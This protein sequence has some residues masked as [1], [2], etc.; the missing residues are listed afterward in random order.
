MKFTSHFYLFFLVTPLC[1]Q[2]DQ[3]SVCN[4]KYSL[5]AHAPLYDSKGDIIL[6]LYTGQTVDCLRGPQDGFIRVRVSQHGQTHEGVIFEGFLKLQETK[7]NIILERKETIGS[8]NRFGSAYSLSGNLSYEDDPEIDQFFDQRITKSLHPPTQGM[9][10]VNPITGQP[11][12]QLATSAN[13]DSGPEFLKAFDKYALS[14]NPLRSLYEASP[15]TFKPAEVNYERFDNSPAK[16]KLGY[17]P[18]KVGTDGYKDQLKRYQQYEMEYI[19]KNYTLPFFI[20][21]ALLFLLIYRKSFLKRLN[22]LVNNNFSNE[23]NVRS[24]YFKVPRQKVGSS[25][26][27]LKEE[28]ETLKILKNEGIIDEDEFIERK[29]RLRQKY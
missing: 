18:H 26:D 27:E 5:T 7:E 16:E 20:V 23:R 25:I 2:N 29:E 1:A 24:N 3:S 28:I 9:N 15:Q 21:V 14:N 11:T 17:Y 8:Y 12:G 6:Y 19:A 22:A 4:D 13:Q 10:L